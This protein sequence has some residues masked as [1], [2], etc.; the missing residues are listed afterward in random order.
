MHAQSVT[1]HRLVMFTQCYIG[2]SEC[3]S[4]VVFAYVHASRHADNQEAACFEQAAY[5]A[6]LVQLK[7]NISSN[8]RM[9]DLVWKAAS[10]SALTFAASAIALSFD[11]M[12]GCCHATPCMQHVLVDVLDMFLAHLLLSIG[13]KSLATERH[14]L[15]VKQP[16]SHSHRC[17]I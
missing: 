1:V 5:A 13:E 3:D 12:A 4:V 7:V 11:T 14:R 17:L 8:A 9:Q 2:I 6:G 10:S 15:A 16:C